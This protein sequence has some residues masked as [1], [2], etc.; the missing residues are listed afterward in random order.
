MLSFR[1]SIPA[2]S[3]IPFA[4]TWPLQLPGVLAAPGNRSAY[5]PLAGLGIYLRQLPRFLWQFPRFH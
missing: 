2:F 3:R 5:L 4:F 1:K